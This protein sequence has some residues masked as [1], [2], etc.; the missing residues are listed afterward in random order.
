MPDDNSSEASS[1]FSRRTCN[2]THRF[3]NEIK[4]CKVVN[5]LALSLKMSLKMM[6]QIESYLHYTFDCLADLDYVSL[7]C[8]I[9]RMK[10]R[11]L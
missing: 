8:F 2:R 9:F 3:V 4:I 11:F 5:D 1:D 7:V 10:W 6:N